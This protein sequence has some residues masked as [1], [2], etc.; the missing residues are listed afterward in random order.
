MDEQKPSQ[1]VVVCGRR[2]KSW[3]SPLTFLRKLT[4]NE[5]FRHVCQLVGFLMLLQKICFLYI[6]LLGEIRISCPFFHCPK[7]RIVQ[8]ICVTFSFI[9][10]GGNKHL[11]S[12]LLF[13]EAS[14]S[15]HNMCFSLLLHVGNK[16]R[17]S[18][19]FPETSEFIG[20]CKPV[21]KKT[22]SVPVCNMHWHHVVFR[23]RGN[24]GKW[25]DGAGSSMCWM[26]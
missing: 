23:W 12:L 25:W 6:L 8:I 2:H 11:I 14:S 18:L 10:I 15:R 5:G 26:P 22:E 21:R 1:M 13:L 7:H 3:T 17:V 19:L 24:C 20:H 4:T 9:C 16:H